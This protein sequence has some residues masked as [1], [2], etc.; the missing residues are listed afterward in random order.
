MNKLELEKDAVAIITDRLD[1]K[2]FSGVDLAEGYLVV[3]NKLTYFTD[4][5]Y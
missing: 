2:Y 5:R 3:A 4:D 1:R